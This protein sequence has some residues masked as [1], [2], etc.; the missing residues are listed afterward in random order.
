M[1]QVFVLKTK[2]KSVL[3]DY[4]RLM[5]MADY[6]KSL[7]SSKEILLKLNLSWNLYFPSCSTQPWQLEGV[8]K[9]SWGRLFE[10]YG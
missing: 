1:S 6:E 7:K 4:Q 10:N 5:H 8:L 2:P 3:E 9:T